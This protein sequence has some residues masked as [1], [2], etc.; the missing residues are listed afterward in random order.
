M[1][2]HGRIGR[3]Q[4]DQ[5]GVVVGQPTGKGRVQGIA[6]FPEPGLLLGAVAAMHQ[7]RQFC[8]FHRKGGP[9]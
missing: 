4:V 7:R 5:A 3:R 9:V 8:P 2:Q 1:V 6:D